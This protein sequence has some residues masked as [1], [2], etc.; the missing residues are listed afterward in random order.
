MTPVTR[1]NNLDEP[2]NQYTCHRFLNFNTRKSHEYYAG[3]AK[4]GPRQSKNI[5]EKGD[6]RK[7][8]VFQFKICT[9]QPYQIFERHNN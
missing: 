1:V 3:C 5:G 7:N 6:V 4:I 8:C 2:F 9:S